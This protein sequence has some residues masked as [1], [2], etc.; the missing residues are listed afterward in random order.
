M[1]AILCGAIALLGALVQWRSEA[2]L[3][4]GVE[5]IAE[6]VGVARRSTQS[7]QGSSTRERYF[8][9]F[10]WQ[11]NGRSRGR[12]GWAVSDSY[13]RQ[14]KLAAWA[15]GNGTVVRIRYRPHDPAAPPVLMDDR[16]FYGRVSSRLL[17]AL[18]FGFVVPGA[19]GLFVLRRLRRRDAEMRRPRPV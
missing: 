16:G 5:T 11:V 7:I 2:T 6:V 17:I 15:R 13:A 14:L 1:A 4:A 10:R 18:T 8:I 3:T 9:D 19:I 12:E